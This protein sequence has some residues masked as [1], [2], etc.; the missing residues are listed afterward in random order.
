MRVKEREIN[1]RIGTLIKRK[2]GEWRKVKNGGK[3]VKSDDQK[4]EWWR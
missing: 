3:W 2:N 1:H 4:V